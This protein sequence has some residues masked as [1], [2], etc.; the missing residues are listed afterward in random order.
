MLPLVKP[1]AALMACTVV[2]CARAIRAKESPDLT[3]YRVC[4]L[5]VTAVGWLAVPSAAAGAKAELVVPGSAPTGS[6]NT[7]PTF[8]SALLMPGFAS[9]SAFCETPF[10]LAIL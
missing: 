2:P 3:T 8:N 6:C 4:A 10:A 5:P 7:W 9:A 1:L